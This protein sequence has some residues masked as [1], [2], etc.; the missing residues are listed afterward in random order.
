[1]NTLEI[2][3][4]VRKDGEMLSGFPFTRRLEVDESQGFDYQE[5]ADNDTTTFSALPT[6][7]IDTIQALIVK[8]D[9]PITLRLDAQSDAGIMLNA[10]GMLVIVDATIDAGAST[11]ATVNNPDASV[12]AVVKGIAAGT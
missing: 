12:S 11:N 7:F 1:M 3:I 4:T 10:G 8:T 2:T 5:P 9:L 6:S